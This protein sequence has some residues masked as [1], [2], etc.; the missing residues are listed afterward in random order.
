MQKLQL[1]VAPELGQIETL[2]L[3]HH[4]QL[5][6]VA[7]AQFLN[8]LEALLTAHLVVELLEQLRSDIAIQFLLAAIVVVKVLW[9]PETLL[10]SK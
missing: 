10:A 1:I 4:A 3:D 8:L 2:V 6:A 7:C 9:I 5:L